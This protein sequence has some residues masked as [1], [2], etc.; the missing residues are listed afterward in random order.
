MKH[1][2]QI[3]NHTLLVMVVASLTGCALDDTPRAKS[4][5][6]AE[7]QAGLE[8]LK[9]K[10]ARLQAVQATNSETARLQAV[11]AANSLEDVK[12]EMERLQAVITE[13]SARVFHLEETT[14]KLNGVQKI[15]LLRPGSQDYSQVQLDL[16]S[17]IVQIADVKLHPNGSKVVIKFGNPLSASITGLSG[18]VEW[19]KTDEGGHPIAKQSNTKEIQFSETI[20]PA[21]WTRTSIILEGA[22]P[23]DLGYVRLKNFTHKGITLLVK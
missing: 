18:T 23:T 16:G 14:E 3:I 5:D 9:A 2:Q 1:S 22:P 7:M 17:L 8:N 21:S 15:A 4:T 13:L 11:Q 10:M 19:G 20:K 6:L 12:A